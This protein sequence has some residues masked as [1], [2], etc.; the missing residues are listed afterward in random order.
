MSS[1]TI[2]KENALKKRK[3]IK[4]YRKEQ[5]RITQMRNKLFE[6][7]LQERRQSELDKIKQ[8]KKYNK[9][10][11]F[12]LGKNN[13]VEDT[14]DAAQGEEENGIIQRIKNT[15]NKPAKSIR[16]KKSRH[17]RKHTITKKRKSKK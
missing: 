12:S 7:K 10:S 3:S 16:K 2:I 14:N 9:M 4:S 1:S 17:N 15:F 8:N 13:K 5:E 6:E 11:L